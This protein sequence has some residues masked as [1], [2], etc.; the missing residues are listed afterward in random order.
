MGVGKAEGTDV[1]G[2]MDSKVRQMLGLVQTVP[3][4]TVQIFSGN[5]LGNLVKALTG[6]VLGTLITAA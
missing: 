4:L 2:G 1:T 3:G 5:E 6:D